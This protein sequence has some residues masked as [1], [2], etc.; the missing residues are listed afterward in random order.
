MGV[1]AAS[2]VVVRVDTGVGLVGEVAGVRTR[3]GRAVGTGG[4][5]S[6]AVG[7]GSGAGRAEA[8]GLFSC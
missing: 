2:A 8:G 6:G 1:R 4:S 3:V 5:A 7:A